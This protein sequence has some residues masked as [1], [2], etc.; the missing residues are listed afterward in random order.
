[1]NNGG[2]YREEWTEDN[3]LSAP[4]TLYREPGNGEALITDPLPS[5]RTD[6]QDNEGGS[7][8]GIRA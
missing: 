7:G 5:P 4:V 1:M 6:R 8:K 3:H 2:S